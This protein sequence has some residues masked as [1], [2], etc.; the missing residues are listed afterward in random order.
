M[1]LCPEYWIHQFIKAWVKYKHN[2]AGIIKY[3]HDQLF[4]Y[5]EMKAL[6]P[7]DYDLYNTA[8]KR[9]TVRIE[10]K[11]QAEYAKTNQTTVKNL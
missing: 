6:D 9:N 2:K 10:Y 11:R 4:T 3:V 5:D 8:T 1:V 7:S